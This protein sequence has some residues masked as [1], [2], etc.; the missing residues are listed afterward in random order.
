MRYWDR[1]VLNSMLNAR[2]LITGG[3]ARGLGSDQPLSE[4][5]PEL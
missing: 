2:F 3:C 1:I 4:R 5:N